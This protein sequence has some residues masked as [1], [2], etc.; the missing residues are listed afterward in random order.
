MK[1]V[2]RSLCNAS[3]TF[4]HRIQGERQAHSSCSGNLAGECFQKKPGR[5]EWN[6]VFQEC[7]Q[8]KQFRQKKEG[9]QSGGSVQ[10]GCAMFCDRTCMQY[11]TDLRKMQKGGLDPP[12]VNY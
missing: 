4:S 12:D 11:I 1:E 9:N 2:C 10:A 7:H 3:H 5:E 6:G 8:K